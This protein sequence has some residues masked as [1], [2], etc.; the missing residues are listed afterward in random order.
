MQSHPTDK[1]NITN[2]I[3]RELVEWLEFITFPH[4]LVA[5]SLL[6]ARFASE[7]FPL[8][9]DREHKVRRHMLSTQSRQSTD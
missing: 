7:L 4:M 9:P 8:K 3:I 1:S 5:S 6:V 2:R